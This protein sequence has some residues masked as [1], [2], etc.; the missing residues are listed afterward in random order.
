MLTS[1]R[2]TVDPWKLADLLLAEAAQPSTACVVMERGE[3]EDV[4]LIAV[5]QAGLTELIILPGAVGRAAASR[6]LLLGGLDLAAPTERLGT[7]SIRVNERRTDLMVLVTLRKTQLQLEIRPLTAALPAT[8]Q[9]SPEQRRRFGSYV[10]DRMIGEGGQATVFEG[11]HELL[12]K[13][14]AIKVLK[15]RLAA[16]RRRSTLLLREG[17]MASRAHHPSV[18]N[19][20]DY[21]VTEDGQTFLIMELVPWPTL[22]AVLAEGPLPPSRALVD[23]QADP[24]GA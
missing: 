2:L 4:R 8:L 11:R 10:V 20:T 5:S 9:S 17:R 24:S 21:G 1:P 23:R 7:L 15:G 13:P 3:G 16:D 6:I 12:G 18:V 14:V 22:E 19:V